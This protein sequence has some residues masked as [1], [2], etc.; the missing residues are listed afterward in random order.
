MIKTLDKKTKIA[1][2]IYMA[3]ILLAAIFIITSGLKNDDKY[4]IKSEAFESS[5]TGIRTA[6][7][8]IRNGSYRLDFAYKSSTDIPVK[9]CIDDAISYDFTLSAA[10]NN[11]NTSFDFEV[12]KNT[13][14]FAIEVPAEYAAGV[15]FDD[16]L[17]TRLNGII[18]IDNIVW[19]M[20]LIAAG[21]I[22][23]LIWMKIATKQR[24]IIFAILIASTVFSC[25]PLINLT[26]GWDMWG[27]LLR[28]EGVKDSIDLREL[29]VFI[30]PRSCKG[31]GNAGGLYPPTLLYF[32]AV[33]RKLHMSV[34]GSY[35]MFQVISAIATTASAFF[36]AYS[37]RKSEWMAGLFAVMYLL[38]PYRIVDLYCRH[39][40]GEI[41][42]MIFLP[43]VVAGMYH[44]LYGE[45]NGKWWMLVLGYTGI[46]Q[47][48][49][50]GTVLVGL[51]IFTLVLTRFKKAF[52][53]ETFLTLLKSAVFILLL[54]IWYYI[55]FAT[56]F[57]SGLSTGGMATG[58]VDKASTFT[59]MMH[60][61]RF[62]ADGAMGVVSACGMACAVFSI[63][64]VV[65]SFIDH[66]KEPLDLFAR[67][68]A[69]IAVMC[70]WMETNF[71][72]WGIFR[73]ISFV[74]WLTSMIQFPSRFL[75]IGTGLI[76]FTCLYYV[77]KYLSGRTLRNSGIALV[78][79]TLACVSGYMSQCM[80]AEGAL[81]KMYGGVS[82]TYM[83]EYFPGDAN[84]I[85]AENQSF[86]PYSYNMVVSQFVR[87]GNTMMI[88]Y[89]T[90]IDGDS[91]DLPIFYYPGYE[92]KVIGGD[93]PAGMKLTIEKGR[94]AR[95][96]VYLPKTENGTI[97]SI[98]YAGEPY[99]YVGYAISF[100]ALLVFGYMLRRDKI[101][102]TQ[103]K[104]AL[105]V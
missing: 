17:L 91:I 55:P 34:A 99:F 72:P 36:C 97:V 65:R 68:I 79:I 26:A 20:M 85:S 63:F 38:M 102:I 8:D 101:K 94:E 6:S 71:F 39:A 25:L 105:N 3:V 30:F 49:I 98:R 4:H 40:I 60:G 100:I 88:E 80:F 56:I 96:R 86:Y 81:D 51:L 27:A 62:S 35:I 24:R 15:E 46:L 48:H 104:R 43:L 73:K 11:A 5:E 67:R 32:E 52:Q 28:I 59:E 70:I 19:G 89:R 82:E 61:A 50:I 53:K 77:F 1:Y 21:I 69:I 75:L 10:E 33:L 31:F 2:L 83:P 16:I 44:I 87:D 93:L 57:S 45:N 95:A 47:S 22:I 76:T 29:P 90:D 54:N 103:D 18:H 66:E 14:L 7:Y 41:S 92:A 13:D 9:I 12:G 37:I 42:V 23:G 78:V 64:G 58:F 84:V 74:E